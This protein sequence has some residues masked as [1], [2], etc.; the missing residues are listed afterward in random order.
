MEIE[1]LDALTAEVHMMDHSFCLSCSN[2]KHCLAMRSLASAPEKGVTKPCKDCTGCALCRI[3]VS[4][5][6]KPRE[7]IRILT[8]RGTIDKGE[9]C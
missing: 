4:N 8:T 7:D 5:Q 3:W 6:L 1:E 2:R 9:F